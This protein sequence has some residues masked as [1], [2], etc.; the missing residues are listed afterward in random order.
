MRLVAWGETHIDSSV[1]GIAQSTVPI[2]T[3]I[4]AAKFLPHERVGL[5]RVA[6]VAI[7]FLGV[8]LLAGFPSEGGWWALAGTL[9]VVLSSVSYASGG[10]YGQL[11]VHETPGPVLATGNMLAAARGAPPVRDRG[12]ARPQM[13]GADGSRR[14]GGLVLIPTF[15]GQ[16]LLFRM[17]AALREPQALDRHVPHARVRGRVRRGAARRARHGRD[18]RRVRAHPRRCR[19]CIG[20][21]PLR[22]ARRRSRRHERLDQTR[23]ARRRR[24]SSSSS[25]THEDVEP[26]LAAVR[27]KGN[28]EIRRRD[29]ALRGRAGRVRA[30]RHRGRR[31]A[32]RHDAVRARRTRGAGSPASAGSPSIR[33]SAERRSPTRRRGCSSAT[34]STTSA[35]TALQ[36]EIYGFNERAMRHAERAGFVREGVRRKAYWRND[37]WVDGVLLRTRRRSSRR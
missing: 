21:A 30:L 13:P 25:S 19:A 18:D 14:A 35:S 20:T 4:L 17:L 34:S 31:R 28:D 9:A 11:Q 15:A 29:R 10:V 2:F 26:F 8:A 6:G 7:G 27:A 33:T 32:R 16:L 36:L 5:V 12:P 24:T 23:A 37:E 3:F 1:A 22:R